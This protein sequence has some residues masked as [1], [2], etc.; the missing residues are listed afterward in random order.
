MALP[1]GKVFG[2]MEA[3]GAFSRALDEDQTLGRHLVDLEPTIQPLNFF[4][5]RLKQGPPT[6]LNNRN[7]SKKVVR[8]HHLVRQVQ[9]IPIVVAMKQR[10]KLNREV[11]HRPFHFQPSD[12]SAETGRTVREIR[13][14]N[15]PRG[16]KD[17]AFHYCN[18]TF[19]EG[20]PVD[21]R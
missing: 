19:V 21:R 13:R 17:R 18:R 4:V 9:G 10:E 5:L 1:L 2:T 11:A 12:R 20:S 14:C 8:P 7:R 6:T 3:L 16:E 15:F